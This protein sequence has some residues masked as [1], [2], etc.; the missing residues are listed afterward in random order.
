MN[1]KLQISLVIIFACL[2]SGLTYAASGS[3]WGDIDETVPSSKELERQQKALEQ[4][5]LEIQNQKTVCEIFAAQ[6]TL[7]A[8]KESL[9]KIQDAL[10]KAY[11]VA[12]P[13]YQG[14][15]ANPEAANKLYMEYRNLYLK[16]YCTAVK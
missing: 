12:L 15:I 3:L 9:S 13:Q 5:Q 7:T 8:D 10:A 6:P 14:L 11:K 4:Q 2:S 16:T 1:K